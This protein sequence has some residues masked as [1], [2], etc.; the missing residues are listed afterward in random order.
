MAIHLFLRGPEDSL[1][2]EVVSMLK[3]K[4]FT[5]HVQRNPIGSNGIG[6]AGEIEH[7]TVDCKRYGRKYQNTPLIYWNGEWKGSLLLRLDRVNTGSLFMD[8]ILKARFRYHRHM[9]RKQP[10]R[11]PT[12]EK[13]GKRKSEL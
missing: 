8:S 5:R 1:R 9:K 10:E 2:S 12:S 4:M 6:Y 3:S 7:Y 11:A 13:F